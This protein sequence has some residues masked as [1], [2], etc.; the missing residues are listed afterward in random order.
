MYFRRKNPSIWLVR[1]PNIYNNEIKIIEE[2]THGWNS[3][4]Q[5]ENKEG[6]VQG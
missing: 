4:P 5:W 6:E 2:T 3:H 1:H